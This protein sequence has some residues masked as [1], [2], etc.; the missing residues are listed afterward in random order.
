MQ[1]IEYFYVLNVIIISNNRDVFLKKLQ[2]PMNEI[3]T[4]L[5]CKTFYAKVLQKYFIVHFFINT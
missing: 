3:K 4:H 1:H 2:N 5:I